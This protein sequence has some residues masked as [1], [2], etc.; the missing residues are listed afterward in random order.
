M[1]LLMKGDGP[2]ASEVH[3]ARY[4]EAWDIEKVRT[5]TGGTR[6]KIHSVSNMTLRFWIKVI[7]L[8]RL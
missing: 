5:T 8:L 2:F 1:L 4:V 3:S 7:L 6:L